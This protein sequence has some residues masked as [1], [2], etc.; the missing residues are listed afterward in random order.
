MSTVGDM[1]FT[2]LEYALDGLVRRGE[3][4]ADNVANVNTPGFRAS[5]VN[6]ED[7]LAGALESGDVSDLPAPQTSFKPGLPD[8]T[9][10]TVSLEDEMIEGVKDGLAYQTY[11]NAYNFKITALRTAIGSG[12]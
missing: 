6:F 1:T 3:V 4:R 5:G 11:V 10:N 2:V 12:R 9:G 7:A 8:A